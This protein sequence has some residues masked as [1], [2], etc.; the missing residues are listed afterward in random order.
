MTENKAHPDRSIINMS[1]AFIIMS[2]GNSDLDKMCEKVIIPSLVKCGF[3]KENCIRIDKHNEGGLL[4]SEIIKHIS[5][6]DIIIADLTN[7]RPNCYLEV[8]FAMGIDKFKNLILMAREDHNPDS[9]N[10]QKGGPKI[11]FDLIGYDILFWEQNN[12]NYA[13]EELVKRLDRRLQL[14]SANQIKENSWDRDWIDSNRKKGL[15]IISSVTQQNY[16]EILFSLDDKDINADHHKLK[17]AAIRA[18]IP[19]T[20]F[21]IGMVSNPQPRRRGI[22]DSAKISGWVNFWALRFD[23][24]YY[25]IESFSIPDEIR[26]NAI[27]MGLRIDRII[28]ALKFCE[29]LYGNLGINHGSVNVSVTH[30]GLKGKLLYGVQIST[31]NST[32]DE[33]KTE[34][35]ITFERIRSDLPGIVMEFGN[36]LLVLFG[37]FSQKSWEYESLVRDFRS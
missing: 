11:H 5:D 30:K 9:P 37:F 7:E 35:K 32:E 28:A 36:D 1:T 27:H 17:E 6:A 25:L 4:K 12:F 29:R 21:P 23:G 13:I 18:Q 16:L 22:V 34:R 33:V 24:D 3:K 2:I 14:L 19:I 8:G 15:T 20:R 10:Y 31:S 26:I